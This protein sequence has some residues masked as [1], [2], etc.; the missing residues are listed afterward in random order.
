VPQ[1]DAG[2]TR[3]AGVGMLIHA[4]DSKL[5]LKPV[6]GVRVEAVATGTG[7]TVQMLYNTG[8]ALTAAAVTELTSA[9]ANKASIRDFR[10][11]E[12]QMKGVLDGHRLP[13]GGLELLVI[14]RHGVKDEL[15]WLLM[16]AGRPCLAGTDVEVFELLDADSEPAKQIVYQGLRQWTG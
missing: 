2:V 6:G 1:V 3:D 15:P 5:G 10:P 16:K 7:Q 12:K 11:S 14:Q 9:L 13:R 8:F 4:R